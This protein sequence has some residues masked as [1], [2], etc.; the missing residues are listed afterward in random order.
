MAPSL[1][2]PSA[3][4]VPPTPVV[5]AVAPTIPV[6]SGGADFQPSQG[7]PPI[8]VLGSDSD[9]D[10]AD[11]QTVTIPFNSASSS[12]FL[13]MISVEERW[14]TELE[15]R[16]YYFLS[17]IPFII[18]KFGSSLYIFMLVK[19]SFFKLVFYIYRHFS[20]N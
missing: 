7:P 19:H 12:T 20:I 9:D 18:L 14:S 11:V 13:P 1:S 8:Q 10:D 2:V 4:V 5:S 15:F 16:Y 6:L 17:V 3:P